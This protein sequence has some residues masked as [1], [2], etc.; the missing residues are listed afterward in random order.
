MIELIRCS[1]PWLIAPEALD[2][3]ADR[4]AAFQLD[5]LRP[6]K[7]KGNPLLSVQNGV[8][9][10]AIEGTMMRRPDPLAQWLFGATDTEEIAAAVSEAAER[11]DVRSILLD[12]DSPGGTVNGVPELAD[13]VREASGQK[14]VHA[15]T[16]GRM[17][18]AAYWVASQADAIYA[19]PSAKV[20]SIGVIVP[21]LDRSGEMAKKGLKMEVFASGKFKGVGMP[22]TSL[23]D[24]QRELIQGEVQELFE[25]FRAAVLSRGRNIPV[26]AMEGQTFSARTAQKYGLAGIAKDRKS[27]MRRIG[28]L[29]STGAKVDS[30]QRFFP[31]AS[32]KTVEEQ[33]ASAIAKLEAVEAQ[34]ATIATLE[35]DRK[36]TREKLETLLA[37]L[38][39]LDGKVKTLTEQNAELAKKAENID[40]QIAIRA[41]QIAA[42]A[43]S[44]VPA[45]VTA[46]GDP[47]ETVFKSSAEAWNAQFAKR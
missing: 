39:E 11:D 27:L 28:S 4:A 1:E 45:K 30:V 37:D 16:A 25:D 33:L 26:E 31:S 2:F 13:A 20:G 3:L 29:N 36:A 17:A 41:A 18:S 34:S 6:E 21:F 19:A 10:V 5:K 9:I 44:V 46:Q 35:A 14:F 43:G 7:L 47:K 12:I 40:T 23:T 38:A 22:G 8:G 32:M 24:E 15:W 42:E